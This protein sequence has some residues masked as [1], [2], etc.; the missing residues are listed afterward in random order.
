VIRE[1]SMQVKAKEFL[2][3]KGKELLSQLD[4]PLL[5]ELKT[6]LS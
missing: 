5:Q 3:S 2:T 6:L 1:K 4:Y